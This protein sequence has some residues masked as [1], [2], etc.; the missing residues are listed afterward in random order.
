MS[1]S[2]LMIGKE[3]VRFGAHPGG[4]TEPK[5]PAGEPSTDGRRVEDVVDLGVGLRAAQAVRDA[6]PEDVAARLAEGQKAIRENSDKFGALLSGRK[7]DHVLD[8]MWNAVRSVVTEIM[9]G[10]HPA[11]GE[12]IDVNQRIAA[13]LDDTRRG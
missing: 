6:K 13:K 7:Q 9:N 2:V 1:G 3:G 11:K 10:P 4:A 5:R 12:V 8:R